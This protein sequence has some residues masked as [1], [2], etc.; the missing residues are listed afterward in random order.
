[1]RAG[2]SPFNWSWGCGPCGPPRSLT[3][4]APKPT[5]CTFRPGGV[6][7]MV[8][9]ALTASSLSFLE[10]PGLFGDLSNKFCLF[11][12][13][14]PHCLQPAV[15]PGNRRIRHRSDLFL[16][17]KK[18]SFLCARKPY[19]IFC[20]NA[21]GNSAND[22]F[23]VSFWRILPVSPAKYFFQR[24]FFLRCAPPRLALRRDAA[25]GRTARRLVE[26]MQMQDAPEL[27]SPC[28]MSAISSIV[29]ARVRPI[30]TTYTT[31]AAA[32]AT[33][34]APDGYP[35]IMPQRMRASP[36]TA[37]A[38]APIARLERSGAPSMRPRRSRLPSARQRKI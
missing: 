26:R 1:M 20:H 15:K 34:I 38:A 7:V 24:S 16:S 23:C 8:S 10:R 4:K 17:A 2:S 29:T 9:E 5:S 6:S 36:Y 14:P 12:V 31:T 11:M 37:H 25:G 19:H 27:F 32:M 22:R 13:Y 28:G 30:I 33:I 21:R 3:S 18:A 35:L